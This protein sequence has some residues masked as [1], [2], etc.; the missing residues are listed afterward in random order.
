[1]PKQPLLFFK[2]SRN[3]ANKPTECLRRMFCGSP[4]ET[5]EPDGSASMKTTRSAPHS[6]SMRHLI[7]ALGRAGRSGRILFPNFATRAQ[8]HFLFENSASFATAGLQ[9][10]RILLLG[11]RGT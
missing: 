6:G 9:K 1:M 7:L 8:T 4:L 3:I 2:K 11:V 5:D 10:S